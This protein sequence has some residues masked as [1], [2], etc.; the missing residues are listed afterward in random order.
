MQGDSRCLIRLEGYYLVVEGTALAA[1]G[2]SDNDEDA[3]S[4]HRACAGFAEKK[5]SVLLTPL[6]VWKAQQG[7]AGQSQNAP[8][9]I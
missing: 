8:G 5:K 6:Y 4:L 2:V 3:L 1:E 9:G 7:L